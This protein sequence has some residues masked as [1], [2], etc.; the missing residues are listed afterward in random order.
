[1]KPFQ[2]AELSWKEFQYVVLKRKYSYLNSLLDE[3]IIRE[4]INY[5]FAK[6]IK[7]QFQVCC[8]QLEQL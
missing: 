1:M 4:L 5:C 3:L 7:R 6:L 8:I 2:H